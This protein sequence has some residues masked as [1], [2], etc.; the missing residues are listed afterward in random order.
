MHVSINNFNVSTAFLH[1][2]IPVL[3]SA[4]WIENQSYG[5]FG[6]IPRGV[7]KKKEEKNRGGKSTAAIVFK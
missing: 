5:T 1:F 7:K 6:F 2:A 4:S 3:Q